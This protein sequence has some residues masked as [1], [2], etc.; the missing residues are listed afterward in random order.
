MEVVGYFLIAGVALAIV[1]VVLAFGQFFA[2]GT[3]AIALFIA[4]SVAALFGLV[5][6][7]VQ[8]VYLSLGPIAEWWISVLPWL[9]PS[10]MCAVQL[11]VWRRRP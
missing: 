9:V 4:G 2:R 10:L 5:M 8:G 1:S 11:A 6:L 7:Y 3:F